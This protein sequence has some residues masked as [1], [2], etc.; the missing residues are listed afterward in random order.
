MLFYAWKTFQLVVFIFK[1]IKV[2]NTIFND[3]G[4]FDLFLENFQLRL[5]EPSSNNYINSVV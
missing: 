5:S 1:Q 4:N 3:L 2:E